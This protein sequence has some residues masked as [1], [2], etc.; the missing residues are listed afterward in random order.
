MKKVA[1]T[2]GYESDSRKASKT[3]NDCLDNGK[4]W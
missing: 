1:L 4:K 2:L 3:L